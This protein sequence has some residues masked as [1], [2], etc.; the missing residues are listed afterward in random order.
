[1]GLQRS[2]LTKR[3]LQPVEEVGGDGRG[4]G[5]LRAGVLLRVTPGIFGEICRGDT[6]AAA[7]DSNVLRIKLKSSLGLWERLRVI[8]SWGPFPIQPVVIRSGLDGDLKERLRNILLSLGTDPHVSPTLAGFGLER[9]APV[10]YE[11]Y[12]P[13]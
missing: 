10:P 2:V 12:A 6:H 8:E 4:W 13:E 11:H 3:L 9:F 1:M 7:V 5:L